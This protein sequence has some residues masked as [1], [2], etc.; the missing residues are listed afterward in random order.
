MPESLQ[1]LEWPDFLDF[2]KKKVSTEAGE[3]KVERLSPAFSFE[4]ARLRQS[5]LQEL[6]LFSERTGLSRLPR[7]G[8]LAPVV[9]KARK[10]A[11]LAPEE[12]HLIKKHLEAAREPEE[13]SYFPDL[14]PLKPIYYELSASLDPS[15]R[16]LADSASPEL[17]AVRKKL[18]SF[19]ERLH[20]VMERLL[21]R[22][23]REGVLREEHIFQRKGRLVLPVRSEYKNRVPGILH[24]VSQ[25]G[26]TVFIE[27]SEAVPLSNELEAARIEEERIKREI[28]KRLSSLVAVFAERLLDL[29][30][31]LAEVDI[32]L[33]VLALA[34]Q[35][36]GNFPV[37]K[38]TG[39]L[40]LSSAAHPLFY[41][42]GEAPV[43]NDFKISPEKPLLIISGPNFGG[44]TVALKTLGL[45]VL[46]AQAGFPIPAAEGSEIPVFRKVL[47]DL[48]DDQTL[49]AHESSFSAHLKALRD[50]LETA[51]KDTLVLLDE[52]GRGTDPREGA[53]LAVAVLEALEDSGALVIATTHY[54]EIK[55]LALTRERAVPASMHFDESRGIPTYK[56]LYG[57]LASSHGLGLAKRFLPE[58]II[59][60]AEGYIS[61]KDG[62]EA[63]LKALKDLERRLR[64]KEEALEKERESLASERE[65]LL[66]EKKVLEERFNQERE[67]LRKEVER[68]LLELEARFRELSAEL[69]R[70]GRK[71]VENEISEL[72]KKTLDILEA[73]EEAPKEVYPG[74]KVY[75]REFRCEGEVL[76]DLGDE[77]EV[78]VGSFRVA[79]SK[80]GIKVLADAPSKP[81]VQISVSAETEV[82][83]A[84]HL[85]GLRVEEALSLV[86]RHIN[87]AI[88]AGKKEVR[89]IHGLGT[90]RLQRAVRS[91]LKDH[92]AVEAIRSGAPFEGGEGVTIVTLA[93][94]RE[95]A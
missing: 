67:L 3:E 5:R 27:P 34:R 2:L 55:R 20:E 63:F 59:R 10:G 76:R 31:A 33:A 93:P 30:E 77:V 11:I 21:R 61:G 50:I 16:D 66:R 80:K 79:V 83:E 18:R 58:E 56:L 35:Y 78:R 72:K 49:I 81:R 87:R 1:K 8:R 44:K 36:H 88:L 47:A 24:D 37:L 71:A 7:L 95:A 6:K 40:K 62:T 42:R 84:L 90:G 73:R 46:M 53:A 64:E 68:R 52:P 15:G 41:L 85:L 29:E 38:T 51:G 70:R 89:I 39:R 48:G 82:P 23:A 91:Y 28:L 14:A 13:L 9:H 69:V 74:Q 32:G 25:T 26:A 60:R 92:E 86:E 17:Q 75:L 4:E 43:T 12:L 19:F 57:T 65:A 54:P 94:K 22:Y 45:C